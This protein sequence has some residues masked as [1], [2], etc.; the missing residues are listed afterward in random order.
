MKEVKVTY[1]ESESCL[2]TVE[3]YGEKRCTNINTDIHTVFKV[4]PY[5]LNLYVLTSYQCDTVDY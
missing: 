1:L 4:S 5:C 3:V 2:F